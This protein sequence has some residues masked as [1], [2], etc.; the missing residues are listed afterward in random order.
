MTQYFLRS[1]DFHPEQLTDS[2]RA[3]YLTIEVARKML[4]AAHNLFDSREEA[5][6]AYCRVR[7]ALCSLK[8][9][10]ELIGKGF[11]HRLPM[12]GYEYLTIGRVQQILADIQQLAEAYGYSTTDRNKVCELIGLE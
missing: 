9:E 1:G 12:P 10:K 7:Q 4:A 6:E 3:G 2:D 8:L 5:E 11:D